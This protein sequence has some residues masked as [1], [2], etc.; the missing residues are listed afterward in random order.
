M[1]MIMVKLANLAATGGEIEK[2]AFRFTRRGREKS[3]E[4][5]LRY[6]DSSLQHKA[7][8]GEEAVNLSGSSK[9]PTHHANAL[10]RDL[11]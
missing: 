1:N 4:R 8:R 5:A 6:Y 10:A 3:R 9:A 2:T 7:W 11:W